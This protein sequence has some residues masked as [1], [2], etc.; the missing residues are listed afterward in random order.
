MNAIPA[1]CD[2]ECAPVEQ[3]DIVQIQ[4]GTGFGVGGVRAVRGE[5]PV[6]SAPAIR[7]PLCLP[8]DR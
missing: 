8:M 5:E 2:S 3:C 1:P 7:Q 4:M 6:Y